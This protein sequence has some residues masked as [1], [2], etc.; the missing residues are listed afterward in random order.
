MKKERNEH[1]NNNKVILLITV[2]KICDKYN[3]AYYIV[4][5]RKSK[6]LPNDP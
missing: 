6:Q 1:A 5:D 2:H 3:Q 4:G